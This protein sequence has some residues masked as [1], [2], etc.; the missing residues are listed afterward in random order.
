MTSTVDSLV[1]VLLALL[2]FLLPLVRECVKNTKYREE[3][4]EGKKPKKIRRTQIEQKND[5]CVCV[6]AA[7]T[8]RSFEY[9][10][11]ENEN[12]NRMKSKRKIVTRTC[13]A[14]FKGHSQSIYLTV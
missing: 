4:E 9:C 7:L 13:A 12:K 6:R 11:F 1:L 8:L 10:V 3:S 5:V 2:L 14:P